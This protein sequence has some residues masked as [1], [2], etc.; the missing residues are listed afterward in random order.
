MLHAMLS[1]MLYAMLATMLSAGYAH[2]N[3]HIMLL[4]YSQYFTTHCFPLSSHVVF[5]YIYYHQY[6]FPI[7]HM[8]SNLIVLLQHTFLKH[9]HLENKRCRNGLRRCELE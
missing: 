6:C 4:S 9:L 2:S 8:F 5:H 7:F 3:C 1:D